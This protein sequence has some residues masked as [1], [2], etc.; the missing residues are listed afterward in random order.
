[1]VVSSGRPERW[2]ENTL[3]TNHSNS[4]QYAYSFGC[5]QKHINTF[6]ACTNLV[7][8]EFVSRNNCWVSL[9][10]VTS[11]CALIPKGALAAHSTSHTTGRKVTDDQV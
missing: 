11:P 2:I 1:M 9:P 10:P 5:M 3:Q 6:S 4:A 7:V 8:Q